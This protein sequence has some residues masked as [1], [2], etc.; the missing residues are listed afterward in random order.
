M[1]QCNTMHMGVVEVRVRFFVSPI[2][3]S[4]VFSVR[5]STLKENAKRE[6]KWSYAWLSVRGPDTSGL[7]SLQGEKRREKGEERRKGTEERE[8]EKQRVGGRRESWER[9]GRH[10]SEGSGMQGKMEKT[11]REN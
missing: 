3:D 11:R 9:E 1:S 2:H 6:Y 7:K 8:E 10:R 4:V 5:P